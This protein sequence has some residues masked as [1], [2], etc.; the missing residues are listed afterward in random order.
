MTFFF[1][2]TNILSF[3]VFRI[4]NLLISILIEK[5]SFSFVT[6]IILSSNKRSEWNFSIHIFTPST[7]FLINFLPRLTFIGLKWVDWSFVRSFVRMW[8][9]CVPLWGNNPPCLYMRRIIV[10]LL[11]SYR[12][13]WI[14]FIDRSVNRISLVYWSIG[15]LF[16]LL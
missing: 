7:F 16:F 14:V 3:I 4:F 15:K 5:F 2:S 10:I 1:L 11:Q 9:F 12:L 8:F 13:D 6:E